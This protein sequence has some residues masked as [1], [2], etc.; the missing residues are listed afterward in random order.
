LYSPFVSHS[1]ITYNEG[2]IYFLGGLDCQ[3]NK[4]VK[5]CLRYN[6]VTEKWQLLSPML[7]EISEGAACAINEYQIV[8]AGGVNN[9][10]KCSD[11]LQVYDIREN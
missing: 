1:A 3:S 2:F 9:Q 8:V 7:F 10:G 4:I 6:I 5:N 11:I